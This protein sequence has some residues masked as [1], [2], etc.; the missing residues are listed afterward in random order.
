MRITTHGDVALLDE[1][2]S[3]KIRA[4]KGRVGLASYRV[5]YLHSNRALSKEQAMSFGWPEF[6]GSWMS[7]YPCIFK[8]DVVVVKLFAG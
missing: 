6:E 7:V 5:V 2:N 3:K 4:R 1:M 8:G